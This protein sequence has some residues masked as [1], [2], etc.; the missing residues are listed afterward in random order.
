MFVSQ[1]IQL[2]W[3]PLTRDIIIYMFAILLLVVITWD[4]EIYWY[5][6]LI[7]FVVYFLYFTIMFQNVR[8]SKFVKKLIK[9]NHKTK[10]NND[11]GDC[12]KMDIAA[13]TNNNNN[14]CDRASVAVISH[15]G[16]YIEEPMTR[17]SDNNKD[18]NKEIEAQGGNGK[19]NS[20]FE[21]PSGSCWKKLFFFY[22]WPIKL[23]LFCTVPN[24]Q[25]YPKLFPFTF[26][27]CIFWIGSNSYLVSWMISVIGKIHFIMDNIVIQ[28][29]LQEIHLESQMPF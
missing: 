28:I 19:S 21:I 23:V 6:G 20:P 22:T 13:T 24:P 5:E 27:M 10:E 12:V 25:Q 17:Y 15:Y 2:H 26:I 7:L 18:V 16:S 11:C 4:G 8:I 3:W 9:R 1:P 29:N 14:H